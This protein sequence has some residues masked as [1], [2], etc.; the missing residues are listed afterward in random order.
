MGMR[1][2]P[3]FGLVLIAAFH[4]TVAGASLS[5]P[6]DWN[7]RD[8]HLIP[9]A[10]GYLR[11][12]LG[13]AVSVAPPGAPDLPWVA[14]S[15]PLATGE[16]VLSWRWSPAPGQAL[17]ASARIFPALQDRPS[18]EGGPV[19]PGP[20]ATIYGGSDPY[21]AHPVIYQG[22]QSRSGHPQAL[23]LV[24]PFRWDPGSGALSWTPSGT[25]ELE[26][27]PQDAA[28]GLLPPSARP[29]LDTGPATAPRTSGAA[30]DEGA[31]NVAFSLDHGF[32]ATEVPSLEGT[33]VEFVI[34]TSEDLAPG[35]N[36]LVQW[37]ILNGIPT[38][39]RTVEWIY[40]NYPQGVD[41]AEKIR[42]FLRDAYLYWG[43]R[44]VLLGG[45]PR[46]VPIRY[47]R[48][49]SWNRTEGQRQLGL[50][51]GLLGGDQ[52]HRR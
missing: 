9:D 52:Q 13:G 29:P 32:A 30:R 47:A 7:Q 48:D 24:C 26:T 4:T 42:L 46:H 51:R 20:D 19:S 12:Q 21:P 38:E 33:P 5:I 16:T 43:T 39:V 36:D 11:V 34:V 40:D 49:W 31:G 8:L 1:L 45:D 17:E 50:R 27:K 44:A 22:T 25:L 28:A 3:L 2:R 10:Q 18:T 15:V 41:N 23:F 37:K 14:V 35:F 6:L